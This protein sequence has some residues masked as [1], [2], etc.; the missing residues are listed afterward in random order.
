MSS[1]TGSISSVSLKSGVTSLSPA[2]FDTSAYVT[3]VQIDIVSSTLSV[4]T[5]PMLEQ[6]DGRL[7]IFQKITDNSKYPNVNPIRVFTGNVSEIE[8]SGYQKRR[9]RARN[10]LETLNNN[11]SFRLVDY[12]NGMFRRDPLEA[13]YAVKTLFNSIDNLEGMLTESPVFKSRDLFIANP[14]KRLVPEKVQESLLSYSPRNLVL[15]AFRKRI[16]FIARK[17]A[18]NTS[19]DGIMY[20]DNFDGQCN[21][22]HSAKLIVYDMDTEEVTTAL[23]SALQETFLAIAMSPLPDTASDLYLYRAFKEA[24]QSAPVR[25]RL[26]R[27]NADTWTSKGSVD[28]STS[29]TTTSTSPVL[30]ELLTVAKPVGRSVNFLYSEPTISSIEMHKFFFAGNGYIWNLE[31]FGYHAP[32]DSPTGGLLPLNYSGNNFYIP[33]TKVINSYRLRSCETQ[34]EAEFEFE[35]AKSRG[36]R[37]T[38][39][40][41]QQNTWAN[42]SKGYRLFAVRRNGPADTSLVTLQNSFEV[43]FT[44]ETSLIL[45]K[46]WWAFL[47]IAPR[48]AENTAFF[49]LNL[50]WQRGNHALKANV[51]VHCFQPDLIVDIYNRIYVTRYTFERFK[52][53]DGKDLSYYSL[54]TLRRYNQDLANPK[55]MFNPVTLE[56]IR[57][58]GGGLVINRG[59]AGS[60]SQLEYI[61]ATGFDCYP[62]GVYYLT[63]FGFHTVGTA[64]ETIESRTRGL[65]TGL[66]LSID[67]QGYVISSDDPENDTTGGSN[68]KPY[69]LQSARPAMTYEEEDKFFLLQNPAL[70]I[71][72]DPQRSCYFA[73]KFQTESSISDFGE[74]AVSQSDERGSN[75][76]GTGIIRGR[77]ISNIVTDFSFKD[78]YFVD[79][80]G[81]LY[82]CSKT[83]K[84]HF[85]PELFSPN[86][87][88]LKI[89]RDLAWLCNYNAG[90]DNRGI[91][92]F[93]P[94]TAYAT[95]PM[96]ISPEKCTSVEFA[97]DKENASHEANGIAV[98]IPLPSGTREASHGSVN[99]K[100]TERDL[101][102]AISDG[103]V[104]EI[105]PVI[106]G[107][108]GK[109]AA[110]I[111][112]DSIYL[113]ELLVHE[114]RILL[115]GFS[116]VSDGLYSLVSLRLDFMNKVC[117]MTIRKYT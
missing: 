9:L 101:S 97:Y 76:Y 112:I 94:R 98:R 19:Q 67:N 38:V 110:V 21:E 102:M 15:D 115:S 83:F 40:F 23:E 88:S 64:L 27:L 34:A 109:Q 73:R 45:P 25:H 6:K 49:E 33:G 70:E 18:V 77:I 16:Y 41:N 20:Y 90:M 62:N 29:W 57:M 111:N 30:W 114:D 96:T 105:L 86:A 103:I 95:E 93:M 74:I 63:V 46:G 104:E 54:C 7:L 22:E 56:G 68:A 108:L 75:V 8:A 26:E 11:A 85:F 117:S 4:S 61:Y 72:G 31:G 100:V 1:V 58:Q 47:G 89:I 51:G 113:P 10:P 71:Q 36:V 50:Q 106:S 12:E 42:R 17:P 5:I 87:S 35:Y 13:E 14:L 55:D 28:V 107:N 48:T 80:G 39:G 2:S 44:S 60:E 91:A 53:L 59:W 3:E 81:M 79:Q 65:E 24:G 82:K 84:L 37:V 99:Y 92:Y 32:G 69:R 43:I 66:V 78:L 116:T 52:S